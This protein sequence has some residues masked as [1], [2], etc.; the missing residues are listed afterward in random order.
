MNILK[1]IYFLSIIIC[2]SSC[3][4]L[5][6]S[7][8]LQDFEQ[9]F[10]Q[11]NTENDD[12]L[13]KGKVR[14]TFFGTS[15]ILLDD[16][17]TQILVD[18]FFSRPNTLK[19]AFG[20]VKSDKKT[21]EKTLA[22]AKITRLKGVLVCHSHYDHVMDAPLIAKLTN[23]RLYGS[24]STIQTGIGASLQSENMHEFKPN[25]TITIGDFTIKILASKHTPP[26]KVFGKTNATDPNHPNIN[27]PLA[28]PTKVDNYIE[29]GTF[30]F[31]ITNKNTRI[32]VK[33]STNFIPNA[34]DDYPC[35]ALFLG[36]AMLGKFDTT[37][38]ND[39]YKHTVTA[40]NPRIVIPIH[41]DNFMRPLT[42]PMRALPNLVDNVDLGLNFLI[43]KTKQDKTT[44]K[45]MCAFDALTF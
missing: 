21:I 18:G 2:F 30:D 31:Y 25:E 29:G 14:A 1:K 22:K 32:L 37:F 35:D 39:Y 11:K 9:Y 3:K 27:E 15:S 20:K 12:N 7:A 24:N 19:V 41:W 43:F 34:L 5:Q 42:K 6:P 16:G 23:A 28:Q 8:N 36:C 13:P 40:T 44:L 26:F 10:V 4:A 33:A 38:Q 17:T 45:L